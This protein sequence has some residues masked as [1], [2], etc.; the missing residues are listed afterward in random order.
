ML[1][2]LKYGI[3]G[4]V[5]AY[6]LIILIE[7]SFFIG[8]SYEAITVIVLLSSIICGCTGKIVD[9]LEQN[10]VNKEEVSE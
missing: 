7:E 4:I 10:N 5:I 3:C 1:K 9:V 6:V 8:M 2:A